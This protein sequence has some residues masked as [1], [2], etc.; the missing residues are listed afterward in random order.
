MTNHH[1]Y[2]INPISILNSQDEIK[3]YNHPF[4]DV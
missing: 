2:Q 1:L 3:V 4:D